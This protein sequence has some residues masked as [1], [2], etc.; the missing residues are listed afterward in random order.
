MIL[1]GVDTLHLRSQIL[2]RDLELYVKLPWRYHLSPVSYPVLFCL[3][4]NRSFPLYATT[5]LIY[6]T[7]GASTREIILVGVGYRLD[8]DR[9]KGLAQWAAWR[10]HDF[11]PVEREDVNQFWKQRLAGLVGE[12]ELEIQSGGAAQFLDALRSEIIPYIEAGYRVTARERGLAGYSD[13]GLFVLYTLFN[14]PQLFSRYF[15]GSPSMWAQLF[16]YEEIYAANHTDLAARLFLTVGERETDLLEPVQRM[17]VRLRARCYLGL[18]VLTHMCADTGHV[19]SY[20]ASVSRALAV[21]YN[22]DWL[23]A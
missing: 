23:N 7:P 11:T 13:G 2:Q 12:G 4:G 1:P 3:D 16:A 9:L 19:S 10:T 18:E 17:A 20:A 6:E 8:N 22:A 5:S 21:L 15:A 14:A